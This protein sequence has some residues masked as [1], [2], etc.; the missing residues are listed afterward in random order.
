VIYVPEPLVGL[1]PVDFVLK[2]FSDA[3]TCQQEFDKY[4]NATSY[5]GS[6]EAIARPVA[7]ADVGAALPA[8][9]DC[10]VIK[11]NAARTLDMS[12]CSAD[13][14][15]KACHAAG[16]ALSALHNTGYVHCD[17]SLR[18]LLVTCNDNVLLTDFGS[19]SEKDSPVN[20]IL[21][22]RLFASHRLE[23]NGVYGC[24]DDWIGLF[25]VLVAYARR[26][27]WQLDSQHSFRMLPFQDLEGLQLANFC[28][29]KRLVRSYVHQKAGDLSSAYWRRT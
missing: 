8:G 9:V 21:L 18:N 19:L 11:P 26:T 29:S 6:T 14:F 7:L 4:R 24:L 27:R 20:Q 10:F 28:F 3:K 17:L 5:A 16:A 22:T 23:E 25:F 15:V 1:A 2:S 13:L 12:E